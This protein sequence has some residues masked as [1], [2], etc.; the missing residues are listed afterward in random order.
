V[1][2]I[3]AKN[4]QDQRIWNLENISSA[5]LFRSLLFT[6]ICGES[7]NREFLRK[8]RARDFKFVRFSILRPVIRSAVKFKSVSSEEGVKSNCPV[9]AYQASIRVDLRAS[10]GTAQVEWDLVPLCTS[11]A[12]M[13]SRAPSYG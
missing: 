10:V 2:N 12:A 9:S 5:L 4:K 8:L 6:V 11:G 3:S 13:K 7:E 1:A